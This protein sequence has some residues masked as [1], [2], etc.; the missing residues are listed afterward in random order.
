MTVEERKP[1]S[2]EV[3][4]FSFPGR[5]DQLR[6]ANHWLECK[7]KADGID[8]NLW[9]IHDNLYDLSAFASRH[10]GGRRWIE[11]TKGTDITEAFEV[12]KKYLMIRD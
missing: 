12:S 3:E 4:D 9:R 10:P 5:R 2:H 6:G 1:S 7:R 8:K 11:V